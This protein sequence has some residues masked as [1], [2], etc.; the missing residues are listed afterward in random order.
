METGQA[1]AMA[2]LRTEFLATLEARIQ[3][4]AAADAAT[5]E[6]QTQL[7]ALMKS[8]PDVHA[9]LEAHIYQANLASANAATALSNLRDAADD[10]VAYVR[11]KVEATYTQGGGGDAPDLL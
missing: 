4:V 10:I 5:T 7:V 2:S 3:E 6:D 1:Q 9:A 11:N 8:I